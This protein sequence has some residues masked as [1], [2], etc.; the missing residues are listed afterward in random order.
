MPAFLLDSNPHC[1]AQTC[2]ALETI[3]KTRAH[4]VCCVLAAC[5]GV[6]V[7]C[8]VLLAEQRVLPPRPARP[9]RFSRWSV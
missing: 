7:P 3:A 8:N 2:T 6:D 1:V 4:V 9:R 5:V